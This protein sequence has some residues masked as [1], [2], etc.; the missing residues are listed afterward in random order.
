MP[1]IPSPHEVALPLWFWVLCLLISLVTGVLGSLGIRLLFPKLWH[2]DATAT[3]VDKEASAARQQAEAAKAMAE[4]VDLI[5]QKALESVKQ[6]EARSKVN[7][8][9]IVELTDKI[10]EQASS[11]FQLTRITEQ[12]RSEIASCHSEKALAHQTISLREEEIATLKREI[13][14]RNIEIA[15][16]REKARLIGL[17]LS[18]I[19]LP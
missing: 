7:R 18:N 19:S 9:L 17:D 3:I 10:A 15:E 5:A 13:A 12:L 6:Q 2:R 11:L 4:S 14:A 8:R 1:V 16:L